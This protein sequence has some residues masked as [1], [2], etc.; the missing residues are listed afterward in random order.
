MLS[1][2]FFN[3]NELDTSCNKTMILLGM[4]AIYDSH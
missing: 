3:S 1:F 2:I 4:E